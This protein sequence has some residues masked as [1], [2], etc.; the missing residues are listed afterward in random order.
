MDNEIEYSKRL[1]KL[2]TEQFQAA[3]TKFKLGDY[4][5]AESVSSGL[6]GQNVI[7]SSTKGKYILRGKPHYPWQ[8]PKEKY[9]A[10]LLHKYTKVPVPYPY[11][12]EPTTDIFGWSFII[13]PFMPGINPTNEKISINEKINISFAL[14]KNLADLHQCKWPFP[15]Q[16]DLFTGTIK[17]FDDSYN[18]WFIKEIEQRLARISENCGISENEVFWVREYLNK[19]ISALLD[20][21]QPCFV[22]N[23][24][25]PG[26]VVVKKVNGE[27]IISGL[28]D[29]MEYYFGDGDADLVRLIAIF[30]DN[31]KNIA[32]D[33]IKAFI[34]GYF[35]KEIMGSKIIE[36]Y[37]LFMLRDRLI[38]WEYGIRPDVA[39]F[40]KESSFFDYVKKYIDN[41]DIYNIF[42][43]RL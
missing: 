14:G 39:W 9:G 31:Y 38:V 4:I 16:Y 28:F 33:L 8:F 40:N 7:I 13:M 34:E 22:M 1:G 12:Y 35:S 2:T 32:L 26:N 23:D 41:N 37:K 5:K 24:Y 10:E 25:N 42:M 36:K 3:L 21:F 17:Q 15:G 27:W 6:F 29:L 18:G 43:K 30:L 11:L 20:N 19:N